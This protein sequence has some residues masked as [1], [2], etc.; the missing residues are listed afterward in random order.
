MI[1]PG[2]ISNLPSESGEA[3]RLGY[4]RSLS[5][6]SR[7]F[8]LFWLL[9]SGQIG[10]GNIGQFMALRGHI[11][12]DW[13]AALKA[14]L[15]ICPLSPEVLYS[16]IRCYGRRGE[17]GY[18]DDL[19]FRYMELG[20]KR[21]LND[22]A[23]EVFR[24]QLQGR[25]GKSYEVSRV[26]T[27]D[28]VDPIFDNEVSKASY[29]AQMQFL[30]LS[31]ARTIGVASDFGSPVDCFQKMTWIARNAVHVF[32][33][34]KG[35]VLACRKITE[36]KKI[37]VVGKGV[38]A[39]DSD[40]GKEIDAAD[41]VVRVNHLPKEGEYSSLGQKTGVV[42]YAGHLA[43]RFGGSNPHLGSGSSLNVLLSHYRGSYNPRNGT[44]ETLEDQFCHLIESISYR[45]AT[46]GLR[47]LLLVSLLA[48]DSAT[49]ALYGFDFYS[50]D[51]NKAALNHELN[52]ERWF[53][54]DFLPALT[55]VIVV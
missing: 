47:A 4:L 45:R 27:W 13:D 5:A 20:G 42:F 43:Q 31:P 8:S 33:E 2:V 35:F 23:R 55:N 16:G 9:V 26:M 19:I 21:P 22:L 6:E 51:P 15:S 25:I 28:F 54:S 40:Y 11:I 39:M 3:M 36:A 48:N 24:N 14:A 41:L 49:V 10:F 12:D 32:S 37:S 34:E 7:R 17:Y 44:Y 1:A 52:Y 18:A 50:D 53:T 29:S 38:S 30:G 46:T